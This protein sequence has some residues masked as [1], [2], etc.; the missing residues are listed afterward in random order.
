MFSKHYESVTTSGKKSRQASTSE[1]PSG[2]NSEKLV[3]VTGCLWSSLHW[4]SNAGDTWGLS[5]DH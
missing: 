2:R 4:F 1:C 5:P 3:N